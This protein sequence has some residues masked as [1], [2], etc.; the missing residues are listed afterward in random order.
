MEKR[1]QI[2]GGLEGS[3]LEPGPLPPAEAPKKAPDKRAEAS[4]E[5]VLSREPKVRV[6]IH[7][8]E[9]HEGTKDVYLGVNGRGILVKRGFEV[10]IPESYY[11]VLRDSKYE[12]PVKNDA[13]E[14]ETKIIPRFAY[15]IIGESA[16]R[17]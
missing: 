10:D 6:M 3:S 5:T 2:N 17:A 13:G 9:G 4:L 14:D 1:G 11:H 12:I 8:Q 16:R 15:S 7:E